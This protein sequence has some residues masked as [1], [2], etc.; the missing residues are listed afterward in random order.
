MEWNWDNISSWHRLHRPVFHAVRKW[1]TSNKG[2]QLRSSATKHGIED[3]EWK[4]NS[5][6]PHKGQRQWS[7]SRWLRSRCKKWVRKARLVKIRFSFLRR[8]SNSTS[9]SC[10]L[11]EPF[12]G[13]LRIC[14][15]NILRTSES[16]QF[17]KHD[18]LAHLCLPQ[19]KRWE[20]PKGWRK[21]LPIGKARFR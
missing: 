4:A 9:K 12:R 19:S 21:P 1:G 11:S 15:W 6:Q 16:W 10:R 3:K 18:A 20:Y 14:E 8:S 7:S 5:E 2:P 17:C 13:S